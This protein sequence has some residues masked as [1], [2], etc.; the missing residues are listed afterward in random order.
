ME[1]FLPFLGIGGSWEHFISSQICWG[2]FNSVCQCGRK[3]WLLIPMTGKGPRW[4]VCSSF[5]GSKIRVSGADLATA[6]G[7]EQSV[8]NWLFLRMIQKG[9]N[10]FIGQ[11][12][13]SMLILICCHGNVLRAQTWLIIHDVA[14][15]AEVKSMSYTG[16]WTETGVRKNWAENKLYCTYLLQQKKG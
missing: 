7:I 8:L 6:A 3:L 14:D 4:E 2:F 13:A 12:N 5:R 11:T 16:Q 15:N 1:R 10:H 9:R